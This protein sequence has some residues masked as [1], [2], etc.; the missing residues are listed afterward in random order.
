MEEVV[1]KKPVS[2]LL[3]HGSLQKQ[4]QKK[5]IQTNVIN[6][7]TKPVVKLI[8]PSVLQKTVREELHT[9]EFIL[10]MTNHQAILTVVRFDYCSS[11]N[12][13]SS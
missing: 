4:T 1:I 11:R 5:N 9:S 3:I 2:K 13:C 8:Q 7:A 10:F 6:D 12:R